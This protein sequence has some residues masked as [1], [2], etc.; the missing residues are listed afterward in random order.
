VDIFDTEGNMLRR[1]AA[2]SS[3]GPLQAPWEVVLAPA[4]FGWAS[5]Q[6]LI[7]EVDSG[8]IS[9]FN[10]TTGAFLGQLTDVHGKPIAIDGVWALIFARAED[11]AKSRQLF[12]AAGCAFPPNYSPSL[13][14]IITVADGDDGRKQEADSLS[15]PSAR[16]K[17]RISPREK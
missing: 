1:F 3:S 8:N 2:N 7:G 9:V 15:L 13:F 4:N 16:P 17:S 6:L 5:H 10:P 14:G 12:F 11:D